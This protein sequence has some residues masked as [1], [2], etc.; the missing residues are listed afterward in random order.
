MAQ[1]AI[2]V[3]GMHESGTREVSALLGPML[4]IGPQ[5]ASPSSLGG[6]GGVGPSCRGL[7]DLNEKLLRSVEGGVFHPPASGLACDFALD[8]G[9]GEEIEVVIGQG[10][11]QRAVWHDPCLSI[12]LP[13]I[14]QQLGDDAIDVVVLVVRDP[15]SVATALKLPGEPLDPASVYALWEYY[16]RAALRSLQGLP[17]LVV[18]Y[19]TAMASPTEIGQQLAR[20][21]EKLEIAEPAGPIMAPAPLPP[22]VP[23]ATLL[24]PSA[25]QTSL[26][27]FLQG[28]EGFHPSFDPSDS[29]EMSATASHVSTLRRHGLGTDSEVAGQMLRLVD[30]LEQVRSERSVLAGREAELRRKLTVCEQNEQAWD[31]AYAEL[32]ERERVAVAEVDAINARI[33]MR[34][35][36]LIVDPKR[37]PAAIVR[38]L[39]G[40]MR[41]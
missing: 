4:G 29:G 37:I 6:D 31:L 5:S 3:L 2:F 20:V 9:L 38:R 32:V 25:E 30:E 14:R 35:A 12:T 34:L 36:N 10:G 26:W 17:V 8:A 28:L 41:G 22:V 11:S 1:V 39:L 40:L 7:H 27:A 13:A 33:S 21:F 18:N 19:Q 23:S 16:N 15:A 24:T